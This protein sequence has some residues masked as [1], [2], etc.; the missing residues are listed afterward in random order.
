MFQKWHIECAFYFPV[1]LVTTGY[2]CGRP[3]Q[4]DCL[5][6]DL[7]VWGVNLQSGS[8]TTFYKSVL[9]YVHFS[10]GKFSLNLKGH[11]RNVDDGQ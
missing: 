11:K 9:L 3:C 10:S 8:Q 6:T 5:L 1:V 7:S 4:D 2:L